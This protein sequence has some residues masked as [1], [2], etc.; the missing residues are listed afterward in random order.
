MK[1]APK[2]FKD[3]IICSK[4]TSIINL[5]G[6]GVCKG[7]QYD[8]EHTVDDGILITGRILDQ[9]LNIETISVRDHFFQRINGDS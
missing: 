8:T 4:L 7:C 5:D 9:N 1:N 3:C 6:A 2:E